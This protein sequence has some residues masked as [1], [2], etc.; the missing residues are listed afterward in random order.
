MEILNYHIEKLNSN[1]D[2]KLQEKIWNN[3]ADTYGEK[4]R[5]FEKSPITK[6]VDVLVKLEGKTVLD[7][8]SGTGKYLIEMTKLGAI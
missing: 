8:G 5:I 3:R 1:P 6:L 2:L 7:I 4:T